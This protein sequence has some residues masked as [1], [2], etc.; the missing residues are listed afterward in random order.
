MDSVLSASILLWDLSRIGPHILEKLK[1]K[2]Y[3]IVFYFSFLLHLKVT[4]AY[5][6]GQTDAKVIKEVEIKCGVLI[7]RQGNQV[8]SCLALLYTKALSNSVGSW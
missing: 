8:A 5:K 4:V 2:A 7:L 3:S 1:K 6:V